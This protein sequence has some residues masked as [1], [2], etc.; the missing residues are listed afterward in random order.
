MRPAFILVTHE[1]DQY[2]PNG[3]EFV[4]HCIENI[5]SN[6]SEYEYDI[7]VVDNASTKMYNYSSD[8]I[9]V[10]RSE[11]P[12]GV[13]RA[14]NYGIGI[15]IANKNDYFICMNDDITFD[16]NINEFFN[17]IDKH[18]LK[19]NAIYA[20]GCSTGTTFHYQRVPVTP[21]LMK[22]VTHTLDGPH[23]FLL[24][25]SYKFY[26]K[27]KY[28]ETLMF[29]DINPFGGNGI[30]IHNQIKK[31]GGRS[32]IVGDCEMFHDHGGAWRKLP[33]EI[34]DG[35]SLTDLMKEAR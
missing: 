21:G 6:L 2:R 30:V 28:N 27:Y 33:P 10:H 14:W 8:I 12:G 19:D 26:L 13:S 4:T 34:R 31:L 24:S 22:E 15:A 29:N 32:F 9:Y 16:S 25:F 35:M 5:K 1:S 18:E 17:A 20:P 11:Q 23:D 7:I 3:H